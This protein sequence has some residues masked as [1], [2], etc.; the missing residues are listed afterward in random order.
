VGALARQGRFEAGRAAQIVTVTAPGNGPD[1]PESGRRGSGYRVTWGAVLT[2]AH[3]LKSAVSVR[4]RFVDEDGAVRELDGEVAFLNEDVDIAVL[5]IADAGADA[6]HFPPTAFG[7][8]GEDPTDC[9]ALGFPRFKMRQVRASDG[10]VREY[11]DTRHARGTVFPLSNRRQGGLEMHVAAPEHDPDE[12]HS[13]WEGMSG[14]AVWSGG[15]IVGLIR[16]HH[17]ADGLGT[18]TASRADRWLSHL[19][20]EQA[21]ILRE[22][23]GLGADGAHLPTVGPRARQFEDYLAAAERAAAAHPEYIGMATRTVA[24]L[25]S[26]YLR[27]LADRQVTP[28]AGGAGGEPEPQPEP[29]ASTRLP[30]TEIL[31]QGGTCVVLAGPG[32][33]KSSLLRT[34]L[35]TSVERWRHGAAD[36]AVPIL[37]PAVELV[38][39]PLF[40]AV[41]NA[42]NAELKWFG[43]PQELTPEFFRAPP[44]PGVPWLLLVDGLDEITSPDSRRRL[45]GQLD[46]I[47]QGPDAPT[48]RFVVATR[49]LPPGELDLLGA[50]IPRYQLQLFTAEDVLKVAA[51]WFAAL[52]MPDAANMAL[53]F[54]AGLTRRARLPDLARTPLMTAMLCQLFAAAPNQ[55][56]PDSRG[57]IYRRF[58]DLLY[59]RRDAEGLSEPGAFAGPGLRGADTRDRARHV[60][61]K[62]PELI[63][64]LAVARR[65]GDDRAAL[66]IVAA[67]PECQAPEGVPAEPWHAFL[68]GA[69]RRSGMLAPYAG[70]F[71]FLHPTLQDYLAARHVTRKEQ[72]RGRVVRQALSG[73]SLLGPLRW[74]PPPEDPSYISFVLDPG[75]Q[76]S[77]D[78]TRELKRAA[79]QGNLEG[80][81]LIAALARLGTRLPDSAVERAVAV[82]ERAARSKRDKYSGNPL[83][84]ARILADIDRDRALDCLAFLALHSVSSIR[85]FEA[86]REVVALDR[87]R[88]EDL[89]DFLAQDTDFFRVDRLQAARWL[90]RLDR[91]RG[92][93]VL[94]AMSRDPGLSSVDRTDAARVLAELD[95]A[96]GIGLLETMTR[97]TA[98]RFTA[99]YEAAKV[100]GELDRVR[101]GD[102]LEAVLRDTA[103]RSIY[104]RGQ[105]AL[106]LADV[107]RLRAIRVLRSLTE[108]RDESSAD[109]YWAKRALAELSERPAAA[110]STHDIL[111]ILDQRDSPATSRELTRLLQERVTGRAERY[112]ADA[113]D[114]RPG[115]DQ[116]LPKEMLPRLDDP[117]AADLLYVLARD[118]SPN[119]GWGRVTA[120]WQL[121]RLRDPRAADLLADLARDTSLRWYDRRDAIMSLADLDQE[122]ALPLLDTLLGDPSLGAKERR[123]LASSR[124]KLLAIPPRERPR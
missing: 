56:L 23:I 30:A 49:P 88:A 95:H 1:A 66:D 101:A 11:R 104:L 109:R 85:R 57:E 80:C 107:D 78:D 65:A 29:P 4:V 98:Q 106:V 92:G 18:L 64:E 61:V 37:V 105:L 45:L 3:T 117:R 27:Q 87:P 15:R 83:T 32:G 52:A 114:S 62:L 110:E 102:V 6:S 121:A 25:T 24:P 16:E 77:A 22:L 55:D 2:A 75:D 41:A 113:Q 120:A 96:R 93:D 72:D 108:G 84:A 63:G 7:R 9:E 21:D 47:T 10:T 67:R 124:A 99:R 73:R 89:L 51:A 123:S 90:L 79:G 36:T 39:R 115:A 44:D 122:R 34:C 20:R 33:G 8:I 19:T 82:L 119:F 14:A 5:K 48:V 94:E 118:T 46:A 58:T 43:L 116:D 31:E 81:R 26:V 28:S 50:A 112:R 38:T 60:L 53:R 97:D 59:Q 71:R 12:R 74:N 69:L 86:I 54:A 40:D 100:L 76:G 42:V 13:P 70:D 103:D 17:R 35:A 68:D 111:G 91:A